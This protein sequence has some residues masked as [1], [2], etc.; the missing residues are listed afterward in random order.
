[1]KILVNFCALLTIT[2]QFFDDLGDGGFF[3]DLGKIKL[4]NKGKG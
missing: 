4:G 1:M 3:D 2:A